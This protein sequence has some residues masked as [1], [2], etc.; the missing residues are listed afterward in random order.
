MQ[1]RVTPKPLGVPGG[2]SVT[3]KTFEEDKPKNLSKSE[4]YEHPRFV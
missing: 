1:S 4:A 3:S 2:V